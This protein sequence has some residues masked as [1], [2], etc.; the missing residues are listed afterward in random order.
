MGFSW[1]LVMLSV[2]RG[3]GRRR[4]RSGVRVK[5]RASGVQGLRLIRRLGKVGEGALKCVGF[6]TSSGILRLGV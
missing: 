1:V 5:F 6:E 4:Q 3:F 2:V